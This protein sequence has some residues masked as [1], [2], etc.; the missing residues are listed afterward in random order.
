MSDITAQIFVYSTLTFLTT[1][2]SFYKQAKA[3]GPKRKN[4]HVIFVLK[5]DI[6]TK[7]LFFSYTVF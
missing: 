6:L 5:T 4:N 7:Q 3:K 1:K 2:C